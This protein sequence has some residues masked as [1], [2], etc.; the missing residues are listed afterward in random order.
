MKK[1]A[2][3]SAVI[4]VTITALLAGFLLSFIY[5]SFEKD[6]IA[7]NEKAL[8]D[9]VKA[10]IKN[11]YKIEGPFMENS[12]FPYYIG[13]NEDGSI[14]GY[15][16]LSYANGYNGQN[17]VLVGFSSDIS[18][19][20]AVIVTEQTET[21]GLGNKIT[22]PNFLDQFNSKSTLIPISI[23]K[24]ATPESLGD[25]E[26]NAISGATVSSTSVVNAVNSARDEAFNLL[27]QSN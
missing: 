11:A 26:I 22:T 13:Y 20:T 23:V 17:K 12:T 14:L 2:G 8:L 25:S 10:A 3:Y 27:Y 6:I 18:E 1:E 15:A 21:P 9:G 4:S 7:N 16:I 19:I 24:G 5:S